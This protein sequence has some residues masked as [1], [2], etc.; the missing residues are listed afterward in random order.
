MSKRMAAILITVFALLAPGCDDTIDSD[1]GEVC[2]IPFGTH[3]AELELTHTTCPDREDPFTGEETSV[4]IGPGTP[5][6]EVL[7]L[8]ESSDDD[9]LLVEELSGLADEQS[10]YYM[11]STI[12]MTCNDG[13]ECTW[14]CNLYF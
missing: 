7:G 2:F 4:Y 14:N 9:C 11:V 5:C 6:G 13:F 10:I 8:Y 1:N 3:T 12:T